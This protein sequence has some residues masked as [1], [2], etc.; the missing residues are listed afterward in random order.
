MKRTYKHRGK[1]HTWNSSNTLPPLLFQIDKIGTKG[2]TTRT[3]SPTSGFSAMSTFP[4]FNGVLGADFGNFG[5][6]FSA[7]FDYGAYFGAAFG[8]FGGDFENFGDFFGSSVSVE[9]DDVSWGSSASG[10]STCRR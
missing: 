1:V 4:L 6:D 3:T 2:T 9:L 8:N 5:K 7:E 10:W